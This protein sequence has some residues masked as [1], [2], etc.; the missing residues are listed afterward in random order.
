[1][2]SVTRVIMRVSASIAEPALKRPAARH[3]ILCEFA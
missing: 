2:T 1:V 3:G